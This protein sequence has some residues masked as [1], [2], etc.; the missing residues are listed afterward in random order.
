M[1]AIR[2]ITELKSST[3]RIKF[4]IAVTSEGGAHTLFLGLETLV[5]QVINGVEFEVN[6]EELEETINEL[7]LTQLAVEQ[8]EKIDGKV[9]Y[10][11]YECK[12]YI[13]E[14]IVE[15]DYDNFVKTYKQGK[16][17]D[18]YATKI[19]REIQKSLVSH[20]ELMQ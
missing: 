11:V 14:E 12:V 15:V 10:D 20:L 18:N 16:S 13:K 3:N 9:V 5:A 2:E 17:A 6:D 1:K 19:N 4:K 8:D 7:M